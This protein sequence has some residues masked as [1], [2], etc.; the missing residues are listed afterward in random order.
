MKFQ[1]D[2]NISDSGL[3]VKH[4]D[5]IVLLGSC[6]SDNLAPKF[7]KAGFEVLS[8]PLGT[9]FHPLPL[10]QIVTNALDG[11]SGNEFYFLRDDLWFDWRASETVFGYSEQE[12]DQ[13]ISSR[14]N[15]LK[16][17]LKRAKL[18]VVT[19]GTAWGYYRD[20]S[21]V[22]NCHKMPQSTFEKRLS[23][24][25]E[26]FDVWSSLVVRLQNFNPA[27]KIVFTVSPV[28]HVRD[29]LIENNRSKARLLE[30]C[31]KLEGKGL[32]FPSYELVNDVLRDYRFF[33]QDM[34][35]PN[36]Q[37]INFVW[38]HVKQFFFQTATIKVI[39][40]VEKV[41][42]MRAHKSIHATSKSNQDFQD[43]LVEK[44]SEL[45]RKN[46][47]IYWCRIDEQHSKG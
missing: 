11:N 39:N 9:V 3:S 47:E 10:A 2:I 4:G 31:G 44:Q 33:K 41:N 26:L 21:V 43:L 46:R 28:R 7:E 45:T 42:R 17:S 24:I 12:L 16:N 32:Y 13:L 5:H 15:N 27:L 6:F 37:A 29:G 40:E 25:E 18:L 22:G 14:L 36:T 20:D 23:E 19:F 1:L 34:V 30:L 8:N 35:H 38:D